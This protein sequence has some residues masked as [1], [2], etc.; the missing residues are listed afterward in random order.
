MIRLLKQI[1]GYLQAWNGAQLEGEIGFGEYYYIYTLAYYGLLGHSPA[2]GPPF[3]MVND[4]GYVFETIEPA[5]GPVARAYRDDLTRRS[6]NR[7]LLPVLRG[8]LEVLAPAGADEAALQWQAALAAEVAAMEAD[9]HRLPWQ[10]ALPEQTAA[11]LAPFR[12]RL[13]ASYSEMVNALETG[14]AR[15]D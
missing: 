8:Q 15:R 13:E 4:N 9:P 12:Q 3:K 2:D 11:S 6:L 1:A 5:D 14:I 10:E 7:L